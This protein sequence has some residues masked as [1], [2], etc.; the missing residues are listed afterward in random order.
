MPLD[1]D[2]GR[3]LGRIKFCYVKPLKKLFFRF[4]GPLDLPGASFYGANI[5][6][7]S[8]RKIAINIQNKL[9][10]PRLLQDV[11]VEKQTALGCR[12]PL[13]RELMNSDPLL[14]S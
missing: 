13:N 7:G 9:V 1:S 6:F 5:N 4:G 10:S 2:Q 12:V 8:F 11:V 14:S 3:A